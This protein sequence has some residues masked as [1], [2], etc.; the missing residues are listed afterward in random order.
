[1]SKTKEKE[2][3][4]EPCTLPSLLNNPMTN[5][6]VYYFSAKQKVFLYLTVI[7]L[8]GVVGLVFYGGMFK[9]GE[10]AT[11]A[12]YISDAAFFAIVG[13]IAAKFFIPMIRSTLKKRRDNQLK[14][15]FM[16]LL[17]TLSTS[18]GA[19]GTVNDAFISASSDLKNQYV[20]NDMIIVE[21]DEI[22][23]GLNNGQTIEQ[24]LNNF[25]Q[26]SGNE[27]IENFANV[28]ENCYRIGGDFKN[29][30]KKT[31]D[32][33]SDKMQI[34]EEIN[35]KL[36]SNKIQLNA[37]SLMPIV[38]VAMIKKSGSSFAENLATPFGAIITTFAILI[39]VGAYIWGNK[40][41]D[42]K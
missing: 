24:L 4:V 11:I 19:G 2:K 15:Q 23:S 1:M 39:F 8:G 32:I 29:V 9:Q 25:G 14:K 22:V 35:T 5:Y 38:I 36:T 30:I 17:E 13:L 27:D 18:L 20:G 31:R 10:E 3:S 41:I 7:A 28:M 21:L 12:T 16:D 6:R 33:I 34:N 40:I 26:R 42:V 37:M